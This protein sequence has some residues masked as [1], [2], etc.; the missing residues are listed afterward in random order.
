MMIVPEAVNM[1]PTP[2]QTEI[3]VPG[4]AVRDVWQGERALRPQKSGFCA[5]RRGRPSHHQWYEPFG[6]AVSVGGP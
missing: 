6:Y 1:P 3:L 4:M 2:R 5:G